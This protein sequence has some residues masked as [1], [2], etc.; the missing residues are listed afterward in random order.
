[1]EGVDGRYGY[2]L[3]DYTHLIPPTCTLM[4]TLSYCKPWSGASV[5]DLAWGLVTDGIETQ[6]RFS[7]NHSVIPSKYVEL[8]EDYALYDFNHSLV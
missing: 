3:I 4:I 5:H 1:M 8:T 2:N 7:A 6:G